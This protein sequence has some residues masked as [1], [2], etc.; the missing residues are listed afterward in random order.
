[1]DRTELAVEL[2]MMF[3][4]EN[5]DYDLRE[6]LE[7]AIGNYIR[8]KDDVDYYIEA[9]EERMN[10]VMDTDDYYL[11]ELNDLRDELLDLRKERL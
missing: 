7:G 11:L 5:R 8:L 2:T 4:K 1:M 10:D 6:A 3:I 9:V